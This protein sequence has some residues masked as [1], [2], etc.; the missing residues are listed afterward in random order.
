MGLEEPEIIAYF[1]VYNQQNQTEISCRANIP[2]DEGFALLL[3]GK[4]TNL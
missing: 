1:F 4:E 2:T 3:A